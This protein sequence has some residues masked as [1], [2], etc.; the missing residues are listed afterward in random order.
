M[1]NLPE[2]KN[3][4][5]QDLLA[6]MK[7]IDEGTNIVPQPFVAPGEPTDP[8]AE[9]EMDECG[10]K[11]P[12]K[13]P[14]PGLA[15]DDEVLI[16]EKNVDECGEMGPMGAPK[17]Q[18]NVTMNVSMN[19][20]GAGGIADL[21]KIL[22]NIEHA[23]Q[24]KDIVVGMDETQPDGDFQNATTRPDPEMAGIG[25]VTRTGND[26]ASK[27]AEAEKVN[28]GGNPMGVDE[29]LVAKLSAMYESIKSR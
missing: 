27:G 18:D 4:N 12:A 6:K 9:F 28:G 7:S 17:Q 13:A 5:F 3:M 14:K 11:M 29:S 1:L 21:M 26:L 15:G 25:A 10:D 20:S 16:G 2:D 22:R 24:E 8:D 23:G 19:G